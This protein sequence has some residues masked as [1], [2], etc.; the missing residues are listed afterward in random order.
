MGGTPFADSSLL[1]RMFSHKGLKGTDD[2]PPKVR[3]Y[4]EKHAPEY[5]T[6]PDGWVPG[7]SRVD[8]W[9]AYSQDIPPEAPD[10]VWKPSAFKVPSGSGRRG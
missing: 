8:T 3:A 9:K 10:Y 4:I 1:G 7:N 5:L 2:V 6:V